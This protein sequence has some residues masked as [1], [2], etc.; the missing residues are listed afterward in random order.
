[1]SEL[2]ECQRPPP[3]KPA[4]GSLSLSVTPPTLS[5]VP[6]TISAAP[7][8]SPLSLSSVAM[9]F[10]LLRGL[11]AFVALDTREDWGRY[12]P[13]LLNGSRNELPGIHLLGT[14]VNRTQE[15]GRRMWGGV[16]VLRYSSSSGVEV[17]PSISLRCGWRPKRAITSRAP[18]ACARPQTRLPP[19]GGAA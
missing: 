15:G 13:T 16:S 4:A 12:T 14:W 17:R 7:P 18:L 5:V 6:P 1:M 8:T 2:T 10:L 11:V 19:C 9:R 3:P